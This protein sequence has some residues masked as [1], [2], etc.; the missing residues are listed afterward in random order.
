MSSIVTDC[1]HIV[2]K[3]CGKAKCESSE[4]EG[5]IQGKTSKIEK[6]RF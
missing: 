4:I 6:V 2:P 1:R 5:E 3:A